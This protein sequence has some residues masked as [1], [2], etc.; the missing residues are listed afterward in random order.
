MEKRLPSQVKPWLKYFSEEAINKE[1]P[2]NT[3]YGYLKECNEN[4]LNDNALNYFGK[5]I[6]FGT[7]FENAD[8]A[9]SAFKS[10]GIE[11]GDI[12]TFCTVTVPETV[13]AFYGLNKIGAISN[14]VD[15]RTSSEGICEYLEESNSHHVVV[16]DAAYE[17]IQPIIERANIKNIIVL[18]AAES[19][20]AALKVG[21]KLTN[22]A[23]KI[24]Y[25]NS[26]MTW[27]TFIA[28]AEGEVENVYAKD[29]PATVM[30]TGGTTGNPKGVLLTNDNMNAMAIQF[31]YSGVNYN[32]DQ[33]F[34][35]IM[36]P[37]IAYGVICGLHTPLCLGLEVVIVP[38]FEPS[39]IG[40]LIRKYKPSHMMGVP[41]HYENLMN[42]KK[43]KGFDL[44][45]FESSGSGGDTM[46]TACEQRLNSFLKAHGGKYP[47]SQGY[48][49]TEMSAA[50]S[51][52]FK[53]ITRSKSVGI[54]MLKT[55]ISVFK[56]GTTEELG[57]NEEGEI[58]MTGPTMML[59]YLGRDD[60]TAKVKIM[61]DDGQYWIHSGDIG[62]MDEDGF[63][64]IK[65]RVKRMIIRPD[66]FKVFP[67]FIEN[68]IAAHP[69]V[70][71]CAVVGAN[72]KSEAQG[73]LPVAFIVIKEEFN[74]V[75]DKIR[76]E[77]AARCKEEL[78]EYA[79]PVEY[80]VLDE[81]PRTSIGKVDYRALVKDVNV[82]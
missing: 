74:A 1:I 82:A 55:T 12:V 19:L 23:P 79:L 76:S 11:Q 7:L 60:E 26:V 51:C 52:N 80:D 47:V 64:Y 57:F 22:K 31:G 58:C 16:I 62:V 20:P 9:A 39:T 2:Q 44:S 10:L 25:N 37:F 54:P 33:R 41:T 40:S 68:V 35:N 63:L 29:H 21:Y 56:P 43:M 69:A 72:D 4:T 17:K 71:T 59:G 81:L 27:N 3:V 48:G 36:P 42:S 46:N 78:A 5:Q 18:N 77:I 45:F 66:G 13:Y 24:E 32:R 38:K 49:M 70:E 14:M 61:H 34:L 67:S 8:K 15:P 30:H 50:A 53:N 75:A 73:Q 65:G 28:K 6:T